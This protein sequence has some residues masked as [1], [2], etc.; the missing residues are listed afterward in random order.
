MPTFPNG[1]VL[2][3]VIGSGQFG[4]VYEGI[5]VVQNVVA[6]KVFE[7]LSTE[8]DV[9]WQTRAAALLKEGQRLKDAEHARVVRVYHACSSDDGSAIALVMENCKNGSLMPA[10]QLKPFGLKDLRDILTDVA[11]GLE[12]VHNRGMIHRDIKPSNI[13][14]DD[15]HR[16]KLG[17]F[18]LVTNDIVAGY[19]SAVGYTDHLA[20][21]LYT[22]GQTSIRTDI[23]AFG[24]TAYRLLHGH[25]FYSSQPQ[26][27]FL[28][29]LGDFAKNLQWLPHIPAPWKRFIRKALHDAP[30]K[31]YQNASEL[32]SALAALPI[33]PD[34]I[35]M[36]GVSTVVWQRR[37]KKKILKVQWDINST[38]HEWSATIFNLQTNTS[39]TLGASHGIVTRG[40]AIADLQ[41]FFAS[42]K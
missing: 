28:V 5:D 25:Q 31:R 23:W 27:G 41:D 1:L 21:E 4:V 32:M 2:G 11:Q 14:I 16:A 33:A 15:N 42:S 18:G 26:P 39:R 6:V 24:M 35:C 8:N 3:P 9:E 20:P 38:R 22:T 7:R 30:D 10:Y 17:D 40:Q 34:W 19:G 36:V 37:E 12:I 29:P 13:M